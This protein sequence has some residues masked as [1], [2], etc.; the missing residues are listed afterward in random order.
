MISHKIWKLHV[1]TSFSIISNFT[2]PMASLLFLD[3]TQVMP[4]PTLLKISD[5]L[6]NKTGTNRSILR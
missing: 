1:S 5:S 6:L 4:L 3:F 2:Y